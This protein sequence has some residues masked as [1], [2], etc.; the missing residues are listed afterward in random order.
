MESPGPCFA[1]PEVSVWMVVLKFLPAR[2]NTSGWVNR[3]ACTTKR[4]YPQK[5]REGSMARYKASDAR[6]DHRTYLYFATI[7]GSTY[8][9]RLIQLP[10]STH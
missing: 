3:E 10:Q 5:H 7:N 4:K 9:D 6:W 1:V 2:I 8:F